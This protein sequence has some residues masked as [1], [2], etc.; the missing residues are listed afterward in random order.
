MALQKAIFKPGI[1]R[2]GTDYDNEGGWFDCNLVRFRKGRP[3]KFGGWAKDSLSTFLGTCRALHPWI[4]LS[5][6]KYLGLGTTWKYYIEEGTSF[7]DVTPIRSTTAAGDVTFSA[8]VDGDS[9]IT[10]TD[11]ANGSVQ[12][13]FVTFSGAVSLGGNI[14]DTVL[15]QE[16]QI[17]QS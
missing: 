9:T 16:Y 17:A 15:N 4:A 14:T 3:E 13:D 6:T 8:A 5:G 11:T 12:N 7:N 1:N 10:V 2:E